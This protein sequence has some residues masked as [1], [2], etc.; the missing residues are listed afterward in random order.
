MNRI[1]LIAA[2]IAL[3]LTPCLAQSQSQELPKFEVAAEFTTIERDSFSES[4]TEPGFG[5]RFTFNLNR[6]VSFE[7]AGY[8]FPKRCLTCRDNGRIT[9]VL[10]GVKVGKRFEKWGIFAKARPGIVSFSEGDFNIVPAP[11]SSD[12]SF[13][14]D[15]EIN[16][17]TNFATDVGGVLEFYPSKRIVTRFDAGDTLIHFNSRTRNVIQF[18]PSS[19][20]FLV[21]P[22]RVPSRTTHSFQFMASVGFRF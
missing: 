12:P 13:P 15:F 9:E 19:N 17:T 2:A 10:G 5:G 6:V 7:T 14:F 1:L 21:L 3:F 18:I 11:S 4:R 20:S 16:R 22:L 8:F